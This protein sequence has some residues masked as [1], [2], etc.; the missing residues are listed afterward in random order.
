MS[1]LLDSTVLIDVLR[2]E[3]AAVAYLQSLARRPACSEISRIE[4]L[5]GLRSH[6]RND[7]ERLLGS[8]AWLPVDEAV[9]RRAG[10][11]GRRFR[12]SHDLGA[13]DLAVAAT[14]DVLHLPLATSNVRHFPMF[15]G[16]LPP[17]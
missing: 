11:L 17:Y 3:A 12:R 14:A 10:E 8:L 16:L 9:A 5:T 13:A 6:E 15:E 2:G 4:V 7:G 1:A